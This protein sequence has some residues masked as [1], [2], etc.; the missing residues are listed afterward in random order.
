MGVI[1]IVLTQQGYVFYLTTVSSKNDLHPDMPIT[2]KKMRVMKKD[3]PKAVIGAYIF[4]LQ[5]LAKK[6]YGN[7]LAVYRLDKT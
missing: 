5:V 1:L 4:T 3:T 2:G 6:N 7:L